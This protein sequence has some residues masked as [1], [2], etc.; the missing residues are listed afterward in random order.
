ME[1]PGGKVTV[2]KRVD[3]VVLVETVC[4]K[5]STIVGMSPANAVE[6]AKVLLKIAGVE[7]VVAEPGQ[8]VIRPPRRI[9]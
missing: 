3:G 8:T 7:T 4:A 1:L 9:A 5:G 6:L 2:R